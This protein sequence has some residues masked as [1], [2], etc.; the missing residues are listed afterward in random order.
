MQV[1]LYVSLSIAVLVIAGAFAVLVSGV[2]REAR[3]VGAASEELARLLKTTEDE[4]TQTTQHARNALIDVDRLVVEVTDTV[5]HVD[6]AAYGVERIV[7]TLET[8]T[9][10]VKLVK[11]STGG[12]LS[13][14]EGVKQGI[15][16]L[17]GSHET[18][19]EGTV[20]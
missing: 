1:V 14:Y 7:D 11:T 17:W 9:S 10:A 16:A 19:K 18:D 12:L 5:R 3:K 13:V 20:E 2:L 6:K 4:L 15:R 8:A